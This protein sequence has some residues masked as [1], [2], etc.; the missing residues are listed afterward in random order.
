M[1]FEDFRRIVS[2]DSDP[3]SYFGLLEKHPEYVNKKDSQGRT[4]IF[5]AAEAEHGDVLRN[6][7][8]YHGAD[9]FVQDKEGN[10]VYD[11]I[12]DNPEMN[13]L[14][15]DVLKPVAARYA[16]DFEALRTAKPNVPE[17]VMS[18]ISKNL[19][20]LKGSVE[21]QRKTIRRAIGKGRKKKSRR[22][23]RRHTRRA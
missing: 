19:T 17:D 18:V 10:T 22:Q 16:K 5:Y 13:W 6:L 8:Q 3:R 15:D 2:R 14:L 20:G 12:K 1:S 21:Q 4:A 11:L 9:M 7:I 23:R